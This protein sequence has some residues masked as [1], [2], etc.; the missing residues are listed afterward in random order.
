MSHLKGEKQHL[1]GSKQEETRRKWNIA[2]VYHWPSTATE[3]D[4]NT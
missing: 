4:G 1:G 2:E 3:G